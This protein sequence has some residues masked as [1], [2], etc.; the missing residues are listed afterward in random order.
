[1]SPRTILRMARLYRPLIGAHVQLIGQQHVSND[2]YYE[3]Q[4]ASDEAVRQCKYLIQHLDSRHG[5]VLFARAVGLPEYINL[6]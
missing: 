2:A 1:M 6:R 4:S 5:A 3:A